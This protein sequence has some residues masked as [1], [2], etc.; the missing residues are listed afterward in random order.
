MTKQLHGMMAA[1]EMMVRHQAQP[2]Q[3]ESLELEVILEKRYSEQLLR[4]KGRGKLV[5]ENPTAPSH[6]SVTPSRLTKV[7]R[8]D[9]LKLHLK[10]TTQG[11]GWSVEMRDL[12][13]SIGHPSPA[14]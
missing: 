14:N 10:K 5:V 2:V 7:R 9:A 6:K 3:G 13:P 8:G 1:Q 12:G 4:S 11:E